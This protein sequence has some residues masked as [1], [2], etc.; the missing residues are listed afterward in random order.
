MKRGKKTESF[1]EFL[2]KLDILVQHNLTFKLGTNEVNFS[3]GSKK[4][5]TFSFKK[6]AQLNWVQKTARLSNFSEILQ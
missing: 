1:I 2:L 3:N 5:D 6:G 4:R